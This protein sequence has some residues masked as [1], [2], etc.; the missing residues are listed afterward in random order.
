MNHAPAP[1][2]LSSFPPAR[3]RVERESNSGFRSAEIAA[4]FPLN[5]SL[6]GNDGYC[7]VMP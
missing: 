5:A 2:D 6:G 7:E 3:Q 1:I 4:G